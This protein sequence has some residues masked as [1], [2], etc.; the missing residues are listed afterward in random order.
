MSGSASRHDM[1][2][3]ARRRTSRMGRKRTQSC[4]GPRIDAPTGIAERRGVVNG[5]SSAPDGQ[6]CT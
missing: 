4:A 2:N 6:K 5:M 3:A 1:F